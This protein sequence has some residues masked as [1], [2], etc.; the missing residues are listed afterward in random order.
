LILAVNSNAT[1]AAPGY[2]LFVRNRTL[3]A[4]PFN[5]TTLK[6]TGDPVPIAE[7]VDFYA[8]AQ[9]QFSSSQNGTVTYA[10][11]DSG[12]NVQLTWL[13]RSGNIVGKIDSQGGLVT[14]AI[15]PDGAS[16]RMRGR[17]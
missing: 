17:I 15:S 13:D 8:G 12:L 11:G 2:L 4:Q 10:T 6:I 1:Y 9:G 5:P 3:T 14:P 7:P 16:V